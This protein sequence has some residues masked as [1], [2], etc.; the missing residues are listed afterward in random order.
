M[1]EEK[2]DMMVEKL[3][4]LSIERRIYTVRGKYVMTDKR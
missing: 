1:E 4:D 3:S 2:E